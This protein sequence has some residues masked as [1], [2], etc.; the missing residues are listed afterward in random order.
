MD[1]IRILMVIG[2]LDYANGITSYAMNYYRKINKKKFQIDFIVHDL[3]KNKYYDLI[4]ENGSNVYLLD[5]ISVKRFPQFY[6]QIDEI[7]RTERYDI[8]HCHLLNISFLYFMLAKKNGIRTRIIHSHATKY[9][10]KSSR[11]LRNMVLGKIGLRLSTDRFACSDMAGRFLY[12]NKEY[13]V[14]NNAIDMQKFSFSNS[15]RDAI[16]AELN[17]GD[18]I[19]VG[20]IGRFSEQKNHRFLIDLLIR[21][22]KIDKKYRLVLLGDGHLF[23]TI[24]KYAIEKGVD[25][26]VCF[27]GN[28]DNPDDYYNAFD[29]F[30]LPSL[31]EGLPV[32][33]IEAQANGLPC[34]FANT[35]TEELKYND[36]VTFFPIDEIEDCV[37]L[38][39]NTIFYRTDYLAPM[40]AENYD[41]D[42][43]VRKLESVYLASVENRRR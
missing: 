23:D 9:A 14:I 39:Q 21:L 26:D 32:V 19:V 16:R 42:S 22:K 38:I 15:K 18:E 10:E 24:R 1:K 4:R 6:R 40:L 5:C 11:V 7:M 12:K 34:L 2:S 30:I 17:I 8:V 36:N 43:Q 20:H 13:T 37:N 28:V 27:V 29:L 25:E 31:F 35:I 3:F 41:V 33:G